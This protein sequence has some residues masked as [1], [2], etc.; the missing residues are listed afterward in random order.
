[1]L[2]LPSALYLSP[3]LKS[4]LCEI[5]LC[6]TFSPDVPHILL[7]AVVPSSEGPSLAT[8]LQ[9]CVPHTP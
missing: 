1:M 2:V 7:H 9:N 6:N 8:H 5:H 4:R 3:V